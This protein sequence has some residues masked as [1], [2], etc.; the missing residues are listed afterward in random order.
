MSDVRPGAFVY[1][2][3]KRQ[4]RPADFRAVTAPE[5]LVSCGEMYCFRA[6]PASELR[7]GLCRDCRCDA[8]ARR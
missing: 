6:V 5:P 1:S 2:A 3:P 4:R 7:D 8:R